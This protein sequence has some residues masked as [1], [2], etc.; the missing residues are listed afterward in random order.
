GAVET[1]PTLYQSIDITYVFLPLSNLCIP[2]CI[3]VCIS[4]FRQRRDEAERKKRNVGSRRLVA[5]MKHCSIRPRIEGCRFQFRRPAERF[6]ASQPDFFTTKNQLR[7][8]KWAKVQ[9]LRS[10]DGIVKLRR[11]HWRFVQGLTWLKV[12][13]QFGKPEQVRRAE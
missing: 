8:S 1:Q 10:V 6:P 5:G 4:I 2:V 3:P 9:E 7:D 11:T 12:K 13:S